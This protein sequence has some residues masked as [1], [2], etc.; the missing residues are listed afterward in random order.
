MK[1][2]I[3]SG[4]NTEVT[5]MLL[6]VSTVLGVVREVMVL[7]NSTG[8]TYDNHYLAYPVNQVCESVNF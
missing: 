6:I 5:V 4:L 2:D 1:Y 8:E 3:A 7:P